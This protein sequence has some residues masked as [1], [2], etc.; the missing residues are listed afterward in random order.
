MSVLLSK[1]ARATRTVQTGADIERELMAFVRR[2]ARWIDLEF[3]ET[4]QRGPG[5]RG[6]WTDDDGVVTLMQQVEELDA[7]GRGIRSIRYMR[8]GK[9]DGTLSVVAVGLP[10]NAQLDVDWSFTNTAEGLQGTQAMLTVSGAG[11]ERCIAAFND[12]FDVV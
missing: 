4:G 6:Q 11:E 12:W 2:T 7:N 1:G 8:V 10:N 3:P 5:E 9:G